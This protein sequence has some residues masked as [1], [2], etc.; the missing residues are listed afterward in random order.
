MYDNKSTMQYFHN[1][2]EMEWAIDLALRYNKPV[3]ATM[4]I[5]EDRILYLQ[6]LYFWSTLYLQNCD[7]YIQAVIAVALCRPPRWRRR[8]ENSITIIII[9]IITTFAGP[10]GDGEGKTPGECAVRMA[11]AGAP[12][13][14]GGKSFLKEWYKLNRGELFVWPKKESWNIA[15]Y[16]RS[17]W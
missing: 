1:I 10:Q 17:S 12:I 6:K 16:E 9:T 5:G 7:E 15:T 13:I 4:C 11:K 2:R 14:G 8:G 3:A